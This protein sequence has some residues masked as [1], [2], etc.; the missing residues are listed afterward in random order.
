MSDQDS[1][2]LE[3]WF[4]LVLQPGVGG[5]TP[6]SASFRFPAMI[7]TASQPPQLRCFINV[8]PIEVMAYIFQLAAEFNRTRYPV[9]VSH[10]CRSWRG[11]ALNTPGLWTNIG[12]RLQCCSVTQPR[13]E[14]CRASSFA[15]RSSLRALNI[16]MEIIYNN[17]RP[18]HGICQHLS[19][20]VAGV[21]FIVG[22]CDRIKALDVDS[23]FYATCTAVSYELIPR[24]LPMLERFRITLGKG[25]PCPRTVRQSIPV[26]LFNTRSA[27]AL[28]GPGSPQAQ[29]NR[30]L[31]RLAELSLTGT[32]AFWNF[33]AVTN[34][35]SLTINHLEFPFR[36]HLHDLRCILM[37]NAN[38]LE[39][40][41]LHASIRSP[42]ESGLPSITLPRLR[43]LHLGF[44]SQFEALEF[45]QALQAPSLR[46]LHM[47]DVPRMHHFR[48]H[49]L[50][51]NTSPPPVV[52]LH[53]GEE[54][55]SSALLHFLCVTPPAFLAQIES[56]TLTSIYLIH[57]ER[58]W[59]TD[60]LT[61]SIPPSAVCPVRL[62]QTMTSL[63]TLTLHMP[64]HFFLQSLNF[65]IP[66][67]GTETDIQP[68]WTYPASQ[69]LD[70]TI[71]HLS[72]RD[73][74]LFLSYRAEIV[75]HLAR[76]P[77]NSEKLP[78][79]QHLTIGILEEDMPKVVQDSLSGMAWTKLP[80][81]LLARTTIYGIHLMK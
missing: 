74:K 71:T 75:R 67:P 65:P 37:Q 51:A 53:T 31:P 50:S 3:S 40:L 16:K 23:N 32:F 69:I 17:R 46:S 47:C 57:Q 26:D 54:S 13:R 8:I 19:C 24:G 5:Q 78:V 41:E 48:R 44:I 22:V 28:N 29:M 70:L 55:D 18:T 10:V 61:R 27:W 77:E 73:L 58:A 15:S 79:L 14:L 12:I 60:V 4:L 35:A 42:S 25:F 11:L 21:K 7:Q 43:H 49:R 45:L 81:E 52:N 63:R 1:K 56:L 72:H 59:C 80:N 39:R 64:D 76:H 33:W 20:F 2:A 30:L 9:L 62:M 36:L 34:L 66:V 38:S 68:C 6:T